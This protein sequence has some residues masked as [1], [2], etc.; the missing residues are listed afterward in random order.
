MK[1]KFR[2]FED[3]KKFV[4]SLGLKNWQEWVDY[5]NSGEKPHDIPSAPHSVYKE[6]GKRK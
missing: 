1:S 5:C 4:Q 6:W 3:A 2:S